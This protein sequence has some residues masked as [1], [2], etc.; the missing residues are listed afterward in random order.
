MDN[1]TLCKSRP[2]L[3]PSSLP[4][5]PQIVCSEGFIRASHCC[6]FSE[7]LPNS[8]KLS[9]L[10][11]K[12]NTVVFSSLFIL[13]FYMMSQRNALF[14]LKMLWICLLA[15]KD[16]LRLPPLPSLFLKST[17]PAVIIPSFGMTSELYTMLQ[18]GQSPGHWTH[19]DYQDATIWMP[20]PWA[21]IKRINPA[22]NN[23]PPTTHAGST[24]PGLASHMGVW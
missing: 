19:L 13:Q 14:R 18:A 8:D 1:L 16:S 2:F 20:R 15:A 11:C 23:V 10:N 3:W 17:Q 24:V 4:L 21:V 12:S 6:L 9:W 22:G 7:G 5:F